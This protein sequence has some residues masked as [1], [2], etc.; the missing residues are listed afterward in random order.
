[1]VIP[2][3]QEITEKGL[4]KRAYVRCPS[5]MRSSFIRRMPYNGA[6]LGEPTNWMSHV[7]KFEGNAVDYLIKP[8]NPQLL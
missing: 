7:D 4:Y 3:A 2:T 8:E 1:M 6:C 5:F